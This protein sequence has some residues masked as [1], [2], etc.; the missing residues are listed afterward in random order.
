MHA[1]KLKAHIDSNHRIELQ[2]PIDAPAGDA[3]VIVLIPYP[4]PPRKRDYARSSTIWIV[5]H[6]N[7]ATR[8]K[9]STLIWPKNA[10]AGIDSR[11]LLRSHTAFRFCASF[12]EEAAFGLGH[13]E[14]VSLE[15][16]Q[17]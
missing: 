3:E 4:H 8:K 16:G 10:R 9:K 17:H 11:L 15:K 6:H 1:L 14:T 12:S 2:L 13:T 5:I 7:A